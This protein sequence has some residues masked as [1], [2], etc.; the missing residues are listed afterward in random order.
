MNNDN[1]VIEILDDINEE[2]SVVVDNTV[3][4]TDNVVNNTVEQPTMPSNDSKEITIKSESND[5]K[6]KS[7][8]TFVIVLCVLL[9][10]FIIALPYIS[11]LIS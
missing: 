8:L 3:V 9:L 6:S 10:A 2:N 5:E 1:D 7:G 4:P 11:K